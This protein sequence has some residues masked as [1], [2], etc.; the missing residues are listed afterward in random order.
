MEAQYEIRLIPG[1]DGQPLWK[2]GCS[3]P[4]SV[5]TPSRRLTAALADK[6]RSHFSQRV[7][8]DDGRARRIIY[9]VDPERDQF[10]YILECSNDDQPGGCVQCLVFGTLQQAVF[11]LLGCINR[12]E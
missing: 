10:R 1:V 8:Y 5:S 9:Q 6:K 7:F 4:G 11:C 2:L 3:P 12:N